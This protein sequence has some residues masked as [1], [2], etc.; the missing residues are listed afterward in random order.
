MNKKINPI[1]MSI[2]LLVMATNFSSCNKP[3]TPPEMTGSWSFLDNSFSLTVNQ[4][5]LGYTELLETKLIAAVERMKDVQKLNDPQTIKLASDGTFQFIFSTLDVATGTY[6]QENQIIYFTFL[7]GHYPEIEELI[8]YS[9]GIYLE[10]HLSILTFES[11][12]VACLDVELEEY[13]RLFH[14]EDPII[15]EMSAFIV[16]RK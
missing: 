4:L 3:Y 2:I 7:S 6:R 1:F 14:A 16:Y 15:R 5:A 10:I 12:F 8:G 13:E 11:L 9:D